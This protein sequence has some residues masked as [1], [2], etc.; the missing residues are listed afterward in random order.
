MAGT[1]T[2]SIS[3][4]ISDTI[5]NLDNATRH[6]SVVKYDN[7]LRPAFHAAG[8]ELVLVKQALQTADTQL[9]GLNVARAPECTMNSLNACNAKAKRFERMFRMVAEATETSRLECYRAAVGQERERRTVEVLLVGMMHDVCALAEI[10]AMEEEINSIK[11]A[12]DKLSK[13]EPSVPREGLGHVVSHYGSGDML[14]APG[15]T[16]N[17]TSGSGNQFPGATF[18]APVT[19][20]SNPT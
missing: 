4:T 8:Q 18:S 5:T 6:Y 7:R 20:N 2:D 13:M 1:G 14:Y 12:I 9:A 17:K 19:F 11:A 10:D 3:S 16:V 15:G